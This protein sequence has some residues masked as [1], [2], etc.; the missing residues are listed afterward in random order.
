MVLSVKKCGYFLQMTSNVNDSLPYLEIITK[1]RIFFANIDIEDATDDE[2]KYVSQCLKDGIQDGAVKPLPYYLFNRDEIDKALS[3]AQKNSTHKILLKIHKDAES[4][5]CVLANPRTYL[6]Q[7]KAYLIVDTADDFSFELANWLIKRGAKK[8]VISSKLGLSYGYRKF[9]VEKWRK[10]GIEYVVSDS[11]INDKKELKIFLEKAID[12]LGTVGGIFYLT[13]NDLVVTDL[14][15]TLT[16]AKSLDMLSRILCPHLDYFVILTNISSIYKISRVALNDICEER[17]RLHFPSKII[18]FG[19]IK[20][21]D[22]DKNQKCYAENTG[23]HPQSVSSVL[24]TLDEFLQ[25]P[26][27]HLCS[28]LVA[29]KENKLSE[30]SRCFTDIQKT[31]ADILGIEDLSTADQNATFLDFGI[32]SLMAT[33]IVQRLWDKYQV[34][35]AIKDI[36][37]YTL[38]RLKDL[39]NNSK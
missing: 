5:K 28:Y 26:E 9:F 30:H 32:D 29:E 23:T 21:A 11:I 39:R 3:F 38:L 36:R 8:L 15:K 19:A 20:R 34:K 4:D 13:F 2:V 25:R 18:E 17:V 7:S 24:D 22:N 27:A 10:M 6:D 35:L 37:H 12:K 33:E 16:T 1:Q 31:V 14:Q